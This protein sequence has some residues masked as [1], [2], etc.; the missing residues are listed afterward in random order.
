MSESLNIASHS[1]G[2]KIVRWKGWVLA[3]V[4]VVSDGEMVILGNISPLGSRAIRDGDGSVELQRS[5]S[6]IGGHVCAS[7]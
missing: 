4:Y 1:N 6:G 2:G 3:L 5:G 7:N